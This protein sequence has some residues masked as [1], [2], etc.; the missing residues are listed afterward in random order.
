ML[1]SQRA[2]VFAVLSF[3]V[4]GG[5]VV[6]QQ[7]S[8]GSGVNYSKHRH[9]ILSITSSDYWMAFPSNYGGE[10]DGGKYI[11]IFISSTDSTTAFVMAGGKT[12][13]VPVVPGSTS[14]FNVPLSLEMET[15]DTVE[16]KGVHVWSDD[17]PLFVDFDS[18]NAYTSDASNVIPTAGWGKNYVVASYQSLAESMGYSNVDYPSEF[19]IIANQDATSVTITPAYDLRSHTGIHPAGVPFMITLNAGQS[20]QYQVIKV[21]NDSTYDATGTT[22]S[23]SSP[24]GVVGASSCANI[25]FDF[26]YCDFV[27]E[28]I[29][30]INT[31]GQTYYTAPLYGRTG[32]D[33]YL[34][35]GSQPNQTITRT[36]ASGSYTFA[37]L[38]NA[39]DHAWQHNDSTPSSWTSTAPFLLMQYS[40]SSTW[41]SGVNGNY[42]PFMMGINSVDQFSTPVIFNVLEGSMQVVPYWHADIV[43][44]SGIAVF[45]NGTQL[46]TPPIYD[47]GICAVYRI[48]SLG[49]QQY[50]AA[51]D[52]GLSVSVYGDGY[53]GAVG[54]TGM[55]G[56]S[57]INSLDTSSPFIAATPVSPLQ[58]TISASDN[59][60][61]SSGLSEFEIDSL[62]NMKF[63]RSKSFTD[64]SGS[65]NA[66]FDVQVIDPSKSAHATIRAIDRAGNYSTI[67]KDYSPDGSA[68][69]AQASTTTKENPS[70]NPASGSIEIP[71]T[72]QNNSNVSVNLYD[73]LGNLVFSIWNGEATTGTHSVSADVRLLP[74]GTY[75]YRVKSGDGVQSGRISVEH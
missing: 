58:T 43:A 24:V 7:I 2:F 37:T 16:N 14:V 52:S 63:I 55:Q 67:K 33:T 75:I 27:C 40:N 74:N 34:V 69:V 72:L 61:N 3:L 46:S 41:P 9:D 6:A 17:A 65:A 53:D 22:I 39:F 66:S 56:V 38:S 50:I 68:A 62:S 54:Y 47:D 73:V 26:P 13:S 42:D 51:S 30:P 32:G 28:M 1:N 15:S 44:H 31:W 19:V 12:V 57:I 11:K 70:P 25:P 20:V 21:T 8:A 4:A 60:T 35:I 64:G 5:S 23:A 29:P 45:V 48:D 10:N 71:F 36:D 49:R 18:H 59:G